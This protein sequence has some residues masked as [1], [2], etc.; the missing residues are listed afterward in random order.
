MFLGP[1]GHAPVTHDS[2]SVSADHRKPLGPPTHV[3]INTLVRSVLRPRPKL[4]APELLGEELLHRD[5]PLVERLGILP[6]RDRDDLF[7]LL[8]GLQSSVSK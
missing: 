3:R 4:Y 7:L 2:Q 6:A 8:L 5:R 1:R